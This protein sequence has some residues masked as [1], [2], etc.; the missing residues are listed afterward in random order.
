MQYLKNNS[1][2]V[3]PYFFILTQIGVE[4]FESS[5]TVEEFIKLDQDL[6][7]YYSE[8]NFPKLIF[9]KLKNIEDELPQN[10]SAILET[11]LT[12]IMKKPIFLNQI[13]FDFLYVDKESSTPFQTYF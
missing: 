7:E 6:C 8:K 4:R 10:R 5:R 2:N 12:E 11:W 9:P 1:G 13:I 3:K